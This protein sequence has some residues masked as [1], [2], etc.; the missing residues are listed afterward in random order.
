PRNAPEPTDAIRAYVLASRRRARASQRVWRL[1]LASTFTFMAATIIGL[2]GWIN[3]EYIKQQWRWYTTQRPF[4]AANVGPY[5]LAPA[6]ERALKPDP[7]KSFRECG[8][9]AQGKDYCP[10]MIVVPAGS[11]TMG[12]PTTEK[13]HSAI[14]EP[15]HMVTFAKSFAVSKYE[16][17]FDEWDACVS[18][19]DCPLGVSDSGFGRGQQP[20]ST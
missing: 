20:A 1:A 4:L 3:Q 7:N 17:T 8:P 9:R 18:Y 12:S 14:E 10:D 19:G 6:A 13:G 16:L 15:Q 5:V 11:F 2:I